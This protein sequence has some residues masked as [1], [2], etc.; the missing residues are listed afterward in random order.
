VQQDALKKLVEVVDEMTQAHPTDVAE[1]WSQDE[2]RF[3]L[4]AV[5]RRV[6]ALKGKRPIARVA[7][8]YEWLWMYGAAHPG[9]TRTFG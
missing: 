8:D 2:G 9:T 1:T 3:G 5:L 6:W 7:P 4:Q